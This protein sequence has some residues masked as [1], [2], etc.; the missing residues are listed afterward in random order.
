MATSKP[1][2]QVRNKP[3]QFRLDSVGYD[4]LRMFDGV[5]TEE[6][7]KELNHPKSVK[8]FR[9]MS[10]H[11]AV[12][13]PLS[14]YA[15]MVAKATFRVNPVKDATSREK[16][17]AE[18]VSGMFDDMDRPLS[19][20]VQDIMTMTTY[21]FSVIEK[22]YRYRKK[23]KGSLFD[24]GLIGIKKL[25]LRHQ[26]SI[27][28]FT[29]D[30]TGNEITGVHQNITGIHDPFNRFANRNSMEVTLPRSKVM[31]FNV[32]RNRTNPY[33]TSPLRDIY[34]PWKYLTSI[35]ELEATGVAKDLQGVP[36]LYIPPQYMTADASPEQKVIYEQFKSI[37]RNLQQNSQSGVILPSSVDPET[38]APL[39][40]LELLSTQGGKKNYD[41]TAVKDYYRA[42]IFIGMNADILLMGNTQTGS[43]AL[44][45]IKTSLTGAF[46]EGMLQRIVQVINEDLIRQIYELNGWDVSRRCVL[47]YEGFEDADLE[48]FSKAIQRIGAVGY[49]PKN[50][51]VINKILTTLNVDNIDEDESLDELLPEDKSKS[52]EGMK[53]G[54]SS[55]TGSATGNS[56]D[57]SSD[58]SD[59]SA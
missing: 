8:T 35:E 16:K 18:L 5:S 6:A 48:S 28:K 19:E 10:Y 15:S 13:T 53:E 44:G 57:A 37:A 25:A 7:I 1:R 56:G 42:M 9:E 22:V 47:D 3:E 52:G 46:V 31:L 24:D 34:L 33:G 40:K 38:R 27:E 14:L 23:N 12:N 55:G 41:T 39:F 2:T 29:F 17:Q 11:P 50:H 36:V 43:F 20:V 30:N 45:S 26:E 49:L 58:N 59:N 54:M 32:G 21:G 4:G 51:N